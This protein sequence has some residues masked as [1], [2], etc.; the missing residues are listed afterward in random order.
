MLGG[1]HQVSGWR[2]NVP[3]EAEQWKGRA[4]PV[5]QKAE[6]ERQPYQTV[7]G[8]GGD[9]GNWTVISHGKHTVLN[10]RMT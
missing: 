2:R 9:G 3:A 10:K 1:S 6:P 5:V 7:W 8:L 4:K